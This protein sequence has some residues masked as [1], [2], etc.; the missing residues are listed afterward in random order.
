M[1][2]SWD[3]IPRRCKTFYFSVASRMALGL[4]NVLSD[5]YRALLV[6]KQSD[7]C[8]ELTNQ[9]CNIQVKTD[10]AIASRFRS[11]VLN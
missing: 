3:T 1:A 5:E 10:G 4:I 9:P 8:L 6:P 11:V 2:T 7:R